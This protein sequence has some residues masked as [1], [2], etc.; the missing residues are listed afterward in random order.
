MST[1][2]RLGMD[3]QQSITDAEKEKLWKIRCT[4]KKELQSFLEY[5]VALDRT[6]LEANKLSFIHQLPGLTHFIF[7]DRTNDRLYAPNITSLAGQHYNAPPHYHKY[8][9]EFLK[10]QVLSYFLINSHFV[11]GSTFLVLFRIFLD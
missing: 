5:F 3:L 4:L 1:N 6:H 7:V 8:S 11:L 10:R 2:E 9:K